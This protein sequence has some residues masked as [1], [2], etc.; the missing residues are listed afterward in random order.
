M[1]H[2][3]THTYQLGKTHALAK[4]RK[5]LHRLKKNYGDSYRGTRLLQ[6]QS[7]K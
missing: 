1:A 5:T 2:V 3:N 6:T 4:K 7:L